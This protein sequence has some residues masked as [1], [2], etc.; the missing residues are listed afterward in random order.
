MVVASITTLTSWY[1]ALAVRSRD[2]TAAQT[3]I[4]KHVPPE[5]RASSG[6]TGPS[7]SP[8]QGTHH[9]A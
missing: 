1:E 5:C 9:Y 4:N 7:P 6:R 8:R 3:V 2:V